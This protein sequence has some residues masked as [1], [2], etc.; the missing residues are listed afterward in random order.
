M[1]Y[2]L[3]TNTCIYYLKGVHPTLAQRLLAHNPSDIRI[4]SVVKAE[5]LYG[6][7]RSK[8]QAENLEKIRQFLLPLEIVPFASED[9]ERY[10]TIRADLERAGTPIGPNDLLIAATVLENGGILITNNEKEFKR[11]SKLKTENWTK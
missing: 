11:V 4:P 10:A 8:K 9:A 5:L 2:F 6:A 7:K 1:T 3:D